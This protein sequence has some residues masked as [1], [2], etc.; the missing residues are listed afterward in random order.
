MKCTEGTEIVRTVAGDPLSRC[1]ILKGDG[2]SACHEIVMPFLLTTSI[3]RSFHANRL[4][5]KFIQVV[6]N[7]RAFYLS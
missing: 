4:A 3:V 1:A 2:P 6:T 5:Q 7:R